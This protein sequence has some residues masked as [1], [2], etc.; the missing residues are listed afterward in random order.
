MSEADQEPLAEETITDAAADGENEP[1]PSAKKEKEKE[2]PE[3]PGGAPPWMATF[4][5]MAT[6]LMAFFV[7]LLSFASVNVPKF[8]QVSGSLKVAF[9]VARVV[10][11]IML[12][13]G[14]TLL[15]TEFTPTEAER[16]IIPNKSQLVEDASKRNVKQ[17]T[18]D[19]ESPFTK[20]NELERVMEALEEE[21]AN[22]MVEVTTDG[23][24]IVIEIASSGE[25]FSIDDS[26][27]GISNLVPQQVLELA[28]K[29]SDLKQ[30][31]ESS[32]SMKNQT[33]DTNNFS[34]SGDSEKQDK[35]DKLRSFLSNEIDKGLVELEMDGDKIILRLGQQDSF[36]SGNAGIKPSFETTLQKV[37]TAMNDVGGIVKIEGHTDNV[38][39]GFGSRYKSNWDLS[40]ARSAA[41]A[42]YILSTTNLEAGNVSVAGFADSKPIAP[43]DTAEGR[44]RNRRIEVIVD[45]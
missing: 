21:I 39:V 20:E 17:M 38:R 41:V 35:F 19:K 9:G 6:L 10:P 37:G 26:E 36:D 18:K 27:A 11:K 14:E 3:C 34:S 32:I 30:E 22:S 25:N 4:A 1:P 28:K 31:L 15:R 13:M 29:V 24:N 33:Q 23:D 44:A 7:L 42:D 12:P 43:N 8:E 16:A 5:D 2:C 40:S 45:G